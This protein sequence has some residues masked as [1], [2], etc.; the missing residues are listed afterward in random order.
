MILLFF[1]YS[2]VSIII[3]RISWCLG[4]N[5]GALHARYPLWIFHSYG[6]KKGLLLL[7]ILLFW[8]YQIMLC[9]WWLIEISPR[10]TTSILQIQLKNNQDIWNLQ[11]SKCTPNNFFFRPNFS[12]QVSRPRER[13]TLNVNYFNS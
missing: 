8:I 2:A 4:I 9:Q 6:G 5:E 13:L 11:V 12:R 10:N 7:S 1:S 3:S